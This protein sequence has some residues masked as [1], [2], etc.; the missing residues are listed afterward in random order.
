MRLP[1]CGDT[2]FLAPKGQEVDFWGPW[3][4]RCEV[5]FAF[6]FQSH[7]LHEARSDLISKLGAAL[8]STWGI[9]ALCKES[10]AQ[11]PLAEPLLKR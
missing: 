1:S 5:V 2:G 4:R 9:V 7:V 11:E 10:L 6:I 3:C 8:I